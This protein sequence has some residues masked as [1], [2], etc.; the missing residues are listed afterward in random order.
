VLRPARCRKRRWRDWPAHERRSERLRSSMTISAVA[1]FGSRARGDHGEGSDVD[2]LFI[3][4]EQHP[5]H[6]MVSNLSLSLYP[7]TTLLERAADGDLFICHLAYEAKPI[8]DPA[9][10]FARV[11]AAFQFRDSY[12]REVRHASDL[13]WLL[14]RFADT[15][16]NSSL[17]NRRIAWCVRT[18]LIARSAERRRPVF[19]PSELAKFSADSTVANLILQK[20]SNAAPSKAVLE[21]L[22]RFLQKWGAAD[23]APNARMAD[24]YADLF[25]D[26]GNDV[27][28]RTLDG[29]L[30]G[31][32][33]G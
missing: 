16:P 26:A 7:I 32:A 17:A 8:Y 22:R 31:L 15:L 12:D 23:P 28:G 3:T 19:S 25:R 30:G 2:L 33:Y 29:L 21:L 10:E 1:L 20:S 9:G 18:I 6:R 11:R 14:G 5:R 27:G 24:E 4:A 13:G